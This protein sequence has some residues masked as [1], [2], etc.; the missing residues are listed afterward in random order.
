MLGHAN[1][2]TQRQESGG[3]H[4]RMGERKGGGGGGGEEE[5][6]WEREEERERV[7]TRSGER[8]KTLWLLLLYVFSS[9]L[10]KLGLAR[11]AVCST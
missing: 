10:C 8:E 11:S 5:T 3:A 6:E 4:Q 9:A 7:H 1:P 2:K